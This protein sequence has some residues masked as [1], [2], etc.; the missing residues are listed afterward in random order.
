MKGRVRWDEANLNEI[1]TNKPVRKKI[2][3][4]KTP[5]HPI[6]GEDGSSS[7]PRWDSSD[8]ISYAAHAEAVRIALNKLAVTQKLSTKSGEAMDTEEGSKISIA[9]QALIVYVI[10]FFLVISFQ[11]QW[12]SLKSTEELAMTSS[13]K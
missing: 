9:M 5:Y 13:R 12:K 6:L 10:L 8:A 7:S 2:D 11:V 1:N 4:P 3:E